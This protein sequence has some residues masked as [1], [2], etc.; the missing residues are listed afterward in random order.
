[1][2][3]NLKLKGLKMNINNFVSSF[4]YPHPSLAQNEAQP[5][6]TYIGLSGCVMIVAAVAMRYMG[7][8]SMGMSLLYAGGGISVIAGAASRIPALIILPYV[9]FAGIGT[10][11]RPWDSRMFSQLPFVQFQRIQTPGGIMM[12]PIGFGF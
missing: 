8:A 2:Y 4:I 6:R 12:I 11:T 10:A 7:T 3:N 5:T 9:I 1:M